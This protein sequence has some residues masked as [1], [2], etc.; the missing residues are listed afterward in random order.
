MLFSTYLWPETILQ[1]I[2][3][4]PSPDIFWKRVEWEKLGVGSI[5]TNTQDVNQ[6]TQKDDLKSLNKE[7]GGSVTLKSGWTL[8]S[9]IG[10]I[11]NCIL[12]SFR[13]ANRKMQSSPLSKKLIFA[14]E[15]YNYEK[16][17]FL[18]MQKI[19][20]PGTPVVTNPI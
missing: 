12:N 18:I 9:Q 19:I 8:L 15:D 3:C 6:T 7:D 5:S 20:D 13:Y 2:L 4:T 1:N 14:T 16:A 11:S 17:Q 10:T